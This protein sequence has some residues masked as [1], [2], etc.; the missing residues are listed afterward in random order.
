MRVCETVASAAQAFLDNV[1]A[2]VLKKALQRN[3]F[4]HGAGQTTSDARRSA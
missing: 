4:M 2:I 3:L 1:L